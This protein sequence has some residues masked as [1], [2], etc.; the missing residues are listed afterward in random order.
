MTSAP[1]VSIVIA[2]CNGASYLP[3]QIG[4]VLAQTYKNLEVIISDDCSEDETFKIARDFSGSDTRIRLFSNDTRL[5]VTTN[6]LKALRHCRGAFVCFCD[7]D[8]YWRADKVERLMRLLE[9]NEETLLVYSDLEVCDENLNRLHR[10]FWKMSAT[11]PVRGVLDE[12]VLFRNI[13][14]GCS[15]MLRRAVAEKILS[16][17]GGVP[18]LHDHL[19]FV[20]SCGMGKILFTKEKL[21]KYR[22]H[23]RNVIGAGRKSLFDPEV[24]LGEIR[25]RIDFFEKAAVLKGRFNFAKLAN[26]CDVYSQKKFWQLPY[27]GYYLFFH[28]HNWKGRTQA[29][30]EAL[31]PRLYDALKAKLGAQNS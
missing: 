18:F 28:P 4:S 6:F 12:R 30:C 1:L 20:T 21:V 15:M 31:F 10:S 7:Q 23:Q 14:P 2:T 5:G 17:R 26:F 29:V 16:F 11:Q 13:T 8:D 3:D 19:A 27:L 25:K 22:Q 9:P 24:F